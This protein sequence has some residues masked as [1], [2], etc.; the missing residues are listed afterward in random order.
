MKC[1]ALLGISVAGFAASAA[2][3]TATK[4]GVEQPSS[5]PIYMQPV[6]Q[7]CFSSSGDLVF[8]SSQPF[9]SRGACGGTV[10]QAM[11]KAVAASTE[12][13]KCYCGDS[14]PPNSTLVDDKYCNAPCTGFGQDACGGTGY[15]TVYNTGLELYGVP[16]ANDSSSS[17]SS[18]SSSATTA[19][20]TMVGGQTVFVTQT[21]ESD[22]SG[23][24]KSSTNT[25]GIA[26]GAVVGVVAVAAAVGAGFFIIRRR[27]NRAIEEE[28][29][30]NAA[31]NAFFSG[32]SGK[33]ESTTGSHSIS[34]SRLDPVMSQRRMSDG[35]IADNEDYSRRI[36]RV[37]VTLAMMP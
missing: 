30:R 20:T 34:D 31:V 23:S 11:G 6:V 8:N 28:Y 12:G 1:T 16:Y 19:S 18:S 17:S 22:N 35:S 7:G 24:K 33:A 36:L 32:G 13:S 25:A 29:R 21:S 37:R 5:P 2:A 10:C 26:A 4:M 15:W 3:A 27:R 9:N 14:Y